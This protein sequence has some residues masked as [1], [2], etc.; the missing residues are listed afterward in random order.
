MAS[1]ELNFDLDEEEPKWNPK[2]CDGSEVASPLAPACNEPLDFTQITPSQLGISTQS[3][4]PSSQ[5]KDK[6][7]LTQLKARRRSTI[8]TRGSPETNAL[9]RYIAQQR[10]KTPPS[11]PQMTHA[12]TPLQASPF[13]P[14]GLSSLKQKMAS[15]QNLLEV[16]ESQGSA[17]EDEAD[18]HTSVGEKENRGPQRGP[19]PV[20]PSSKRRRTSP[21]REIVT[22]TQE[23]TP[24]VDVLSPLL[25]PGG[26]AQVQVTQVCSEQVQVTQG[27]SEE[28]RYTEMSRCDLDE[29]LCC[30]PSGF[31]GLRSGERNRD[32]VSFTPSHDSP[33]EGRRRSWRAE[34]QS[35]S[36]PL[37]LGPADAGST[38]SLSLHPPEAADC[39]GNST[40]RRKKRVHFGVPLSPE[41]FDK[42]LPPSTPLQRGGTPGHLS[43][44]GG[45]RLRS[46]LKTPQRHALPLPQPDFNS[47]SLSGPPS[48]PPAGRHG[49]EAQTVCA[50]E[51]EQVPAAVGTADPAEEGAASGS[52]ED[53]VVC[54][55]DVA[56]RTCQE[57]SQLETDLT[58]DPPPTPSGEEETGEEPMTELAPFPSP[59]PE[60]P[61]STARP[62]RS[63]GRKRKVEETDAA[64]ATRRPSRNAA[65]SASGKMKGSGGKR[66][67]G[68]KAVDRSLY[69]KRDY[70]S[71]NPA[72]SPITESL[73]CTSRS[74]TP[75]RPRARRSTEDCGDS[76]NP[77]MPLEQTVDGDLTADVVTAAVMW[78]RRFCG[79]RDD[80]EGGDSAGCPEGEASDCAAEAAPDAAPSQPTQPCLQGGGGGRGGRGGR[81]R[82]R[83]K[84]AVSNRNGEGQTAAETE[85]E[86]PVIPSPPGNR[87][88]SDGVEGDRHVDASGEGD[89]RGDA[90]VDTNG[91]GDRRGDALVDTNGEEDRRGDTLVDTNG[92]EDRRG[93]T[94]VDTNGEGDRHGDGSDG[95]ASN[96]EYSHTLPASAGGQRSNAGRRRLNSRR[97]SLYLPSAVTEEETQSPPKLL[98]HLPEGGP[99]EGEGEGTE[100]RGGGGEEGR[101]IAD[102]AME[103]GGEME[104]GGGEGVEAERR[105]MEREGEGEG[106]AG[107]DRIGLLTVPPVPWQEVEF[108][109]EDVLQAPSR[110]G[111]RSVRRSLRNRSQHDP[112]ASGL[113]WVQHSPPARRASRTR[114]RARRGS[115]CL[116]APLDPALTPPPLQEPPALTP[117][118]LHEAPALTPPPLP[119]DP[120]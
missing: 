37:S 72:L 57:T 45:S 16:E 109:I 99:S 2:V 51:Q 74:P 92:E 85:L 84:V 108:C 105:E 56:S 77:S 68:G 78:R 100:E 39:E 4:V 73:S 111:R 59:A 18:G 96:P 107:G 20:A 93:D 90:L 110:G 22:E 49:D 63:R 58:P 24:S 98:L 64:T 13:F 101:E 117:P 54:S 71:K 28:P 60:P 103:R 14:R 87:P 10:Q 114:A 8:G 7:R 42:R 36:L 94:L 113:A 118:P 43:A 104:G 29:A 32:D 40:R 55:P 116:P 50:E 83:R 21:F 81:G 26:P 76:R 19:V 17:E 89:R 67:W 44:S 27:C 3:F 66:R 31:P 102:R 15:F 1:T 106:E 80:P 9:I 91:E 52:H 5:G 12:H 62:A 88:E 35:P 86:P 119:E 46:L 112:S 34:A 53:A 120:K 38:E 75:Q 70:A 23:A 65:I 79:H 95:S 30:S 69:G 61:I 6:S 82:G 11:T 47:P 97:S 48:P 33:T 41:F 25:T 115:A